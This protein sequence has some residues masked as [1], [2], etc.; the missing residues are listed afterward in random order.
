MLC[1][2]AHVRGLVGT[3]IGA[4]I[5]VAKAECSGKGQR[6]ANREGSGKMAKFWNTTEK[7]HP[8]RDI[9]PIQ[10]VITTLGPSSQ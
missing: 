4:W 5:L 3:A 1:G 2:I 6:S 8:G 7:V 10:S 9:R